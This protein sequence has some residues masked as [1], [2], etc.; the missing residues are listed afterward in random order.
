MKKGLFILLSSVLLLAGCEHKA[1]IHIKET[2]LNL[3]VTENYGFIVTV[4]VTP[5]DDR[6]FY[7]YSVYETAELDSIIRS[8]PGET[9][10]MQDVMDS[11]VTLYGEYAEMYREYGH[12]YIAD[13]EDLMLYFSKDTHTF[14]NLK[15][16]TDHTVIAFCVDPYFSYPNSSTYLP[17][18]SIGISI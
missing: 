13:F 10:A 4:S 16:E 5:D 3:A 14:V 11:A 18:V 6:V 7:L 2:N 1:V 17:A 8:Y 15:P 12:E 9:E